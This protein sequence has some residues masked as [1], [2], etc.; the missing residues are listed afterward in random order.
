M[1][2]HLP[3]AACG[4]RSDKLHDLAG[5][6]LCPGCVDHLSDTDEFAELCEAERVLDDW[7]ERAYVA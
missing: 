4:E 7:H 3:C 2:T 6:N 1:E 5:I